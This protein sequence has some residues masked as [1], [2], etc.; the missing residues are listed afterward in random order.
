MLIEPLV[1]I[2]STTEAHFRFFHQRTL[3]M[4]WSDHGFALRRS[5]NKPAYNCDKKGNTIAIAMIAIQLKEL[6][7]E[8]KLPVYLLIHMPAQN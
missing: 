2:Y 5:I 7:H 4:T 1:L 8:K 3:T 6:F